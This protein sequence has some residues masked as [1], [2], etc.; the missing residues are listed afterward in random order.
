MNPSFYEIHEIITF[1]HRRMFFLDFFQSEVPHCKIHENQ[2]FF[3]V[4][5]T[6]WKSLLNQVEHTWL[7]SHP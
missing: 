7:N 5:L 6:F 1:E 2:M 4:I 3:L